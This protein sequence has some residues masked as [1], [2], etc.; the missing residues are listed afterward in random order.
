MRRDTNLWA[1][2]MNAART[3]SAVF[4]AAI[5]VSL[6]PGLC[7]VL[8]AQDAEPAAEPSPLVRQPTTPSERLRSALLLVKLA[9]PDL[10]KEQ[11]AVLASDAVSDEELTAVREE[12]GSAVFLQLARAADLQPEGTRLLD[13]LADIT[14]GQRTAPGYVDELLADYD[15]SA[16]GR[17]SAI[18]ELERMSPDVVPA[19]LERAGRSDSEDVKLR[20]ILSAIGEPASPALSTAAMLSPRGEARMLAMQSLSGS[21]GLNDVPALAAVAGDPRAPQAERAVADAALSEIG[22]RGAAFDAATTLRRAALALLDRSADLPRDP[23]GRVVY[24]EQ[25]DDGTLARLSLPDDEARAR[26]ALRYVDRATRIDVDDREAAELLTVLELEAGGELAGP[27]LRRL[28]ARGPMACRDVAALAMSLDLDAAAAHA[29]N[30]LAIIGDEA[31]LDGGTEV[32]PLVRGLDAPSPSVA[33]A[34]AKAVAAMEP[35]TPFMNS[36]RVVEILARRL[37]AEPT[38]KVVVIDPNAVRGGDFGGRVSTL[39]LTPIVTQDTAAGFDVAVRRGDVALLAVNAAVQG[40]G[41]KTALSNLAA[42][43]RTAAIPV[44]VYAET[45]IRDQFEANPEEYPNVTYVPT[46]ADAATL[47]RELRPVM[48]SPGAMAADSGSRREAA[49]TLR[50][51]AEADTHDVFSFAQAADELREAATETGPVAR[52][53]IATLGSVA[54]PDVQITLADLTARGATEEIRLAAAS[55][56]VRNLKRFGR[57]LDADAVSSLLSIDASGQ[58]EYAMLVAA[59]IGLSGR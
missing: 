2:G 10:A 35:T 20:A 29:F 57:S 58:S 25:T 1:V 31:L 9:R 8:R 11:L 37:M 39:G 33:F 13:R 46:L 52:D 47:E 40:A 28:L 42:D 56:L 18:L 6:T 54:A 14:V 23:D 7:E 44:A 53:A 26:T 50:A 34:A 41:L 4:A 38:L 51:L 15:A 17:R 45:A 49:A 59:A 27:A 24:F 32:S 3:S 48:A 21:A 5:G 12:Y 16:E 22:S 19:L 55:A 30:A 43:A 36:P